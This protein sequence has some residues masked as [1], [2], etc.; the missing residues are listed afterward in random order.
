MVERKIERNKL[1][2]H[3]ADA[4][5]MKSETSKQ[6]ANANLEPRDKVSLFQTVVFTIQFK[7]L[8]FVQ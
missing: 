4:Q 3:I 1:V 7:Y 2:R 5:L 6:R 8:S